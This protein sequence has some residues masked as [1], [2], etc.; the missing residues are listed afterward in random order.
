MSNENNQPAAQAADKYITIPTAEYVR[1]QRVDALVDALLA[2][3]TAYC[4]SRV[5][6][7]IQ[8]TIE[9]MRSPAAPVLHLDPYAAEMADA[10]HAKRPREMVVEK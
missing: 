3:C 7:A 4:H 1:L 2:D 9:G 6:E 10:L 8:R 5:A